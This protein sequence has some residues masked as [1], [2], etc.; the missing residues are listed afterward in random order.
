M[1][2][3][4]F[5]FTLRTHR[6]GSE[7]AG[8]CA[9]AEAYGY[10]IAL[11]IDHLGPGRTAPFQALLGAACSAGRLKVGTYVLN[12]GYWNPS[13]LAREVATIVRLSGG[14][15]ELGLGAGVVKA[16][17]DA[18]GIPWRP[19]GERMDRVLVTIG[20]LDRLLADE[21]DVSR[22]PLLV[23]G[24][25]LAA[26][27][28]ASGHADIVSLSGMVQVPGEPPG[29][30]RLMRADEAAERVEFLRT[31]AGARASELE[32]NAFVLAVE[33]TD[34]R[35]AAAEKIAAAGD[36]LIPDV[37][38][39][40]DSPFMLIGTEEQIV[41]R[42]LENRERYNFSYLTVQHPHMHAFGPVIKRV[43]GL[44]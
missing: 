33:V 37:Q 44:G 28:L 6:S 19:F 34:D 29:T 27:R 14:R 20:E 38:D 5:G 42:I 4:R 23:G 9:A 3:F 8:T 31:S 35:R 30:L 11:A 25:S 16:Q 41:A 21:P 40:L 32:W 10:D 7:L 18:A 13:I 2:D 24:N 12:L 17:Y 15:F 39:A 1:R 43:R 26:L 36:L 22:P